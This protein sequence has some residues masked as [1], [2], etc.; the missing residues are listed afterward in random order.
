MKTA[1][2]AANYV[3]HPR[4]LV[5]I[6]YETTNGC[7]GKDAEAFLHNRDCILLYLTAASASASSCFG[8]SEAGAPTI[9]SAGLS[10]SGKANNSNA[11]MLRHL[12][13]REGLKF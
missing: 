6:A 11:I 3:F 1:T 9:T 4:L 7:P 5:P 2:Y 12:H 13:Q 10:V 8:I